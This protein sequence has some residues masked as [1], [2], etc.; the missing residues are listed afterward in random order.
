[1]NHPLHIRCG[2][3]LESKERPSRSGDYQGWGVHV[4]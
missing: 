2:Y 1:M 4:V 3:P